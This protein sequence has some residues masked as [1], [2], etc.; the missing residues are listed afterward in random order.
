MGEVELMWE[1]MSEGH[2]R[3]ATAIAIVAVLLGMTQM[4]SFTSGDT[5]MYDPERDAFIEEVAAWTDPGGRGADLRFNFS[6]D[7]SMILLRGYGS[8]N[9]LRV[10]DLEMETLAVLPRVEMPHEV[11]GFTWSETDRWIVAWSRPEGGGPDFLQFFD[12]P[13]FEPNTS[14]PWVDAIDLPTIDVVTMLGHDEIAM[15]A[16]RDSNSTSILLVIEVEAARVHKRFVW[17]GNH[18]IVVAGD[19]GRETVI[20]D[21]GG[22]IVMMAGFDW[23]LRRQ[24][25]NA[26]VG[27]PRSW[28]I[29]V[30]QQWAFGD[31]AGRLVMSHNHPFYNQYNITV[32]EGPVTGF[33]WTDGRMWDFMAA[34]RHQDGGTRLVGWQMM[35]EG[36]LGGHQELC[37]KDLDGNVTMMRPDHHGWGRVLVAFEDGRL[38]SYRLNVR[39]FP[40]TMIPGTPDQVDWPGFEPFRKWRHEDAKGEHLR[41]RFNHRGSLIMLHGFASPDD[42]RVV[43]RTMDTVAVLEPPYDEFEFVDLAWSANDQWLLGW[44]IVPD[45][46]VTWSMRAILFD[47]PTFDVNT[48]SLIPEYILNVTY[49]IWSAV[50]LPGDDILAMSCGNITTGENV[51]LFLDLHDGSVVKEVPQGTE[52]IYDL[53]MDGDDLVAVGYNAIPMTFSP[54]DW[55]LVDSGFRLDESYK[56]FDAHNASGWAVADNE[57]NLTI[58]NGTPREL[59]FRGDTGIRPIF[60]ATWTRFREGDLVIAIHRVLA[61]GTNLQLW[62]TVDRPGLP[63]MRML[64]QVNSSKSFVQME[65]DPAFLGLMAVSFSDG[66]FALYHMN[67]TPYPPPP[68]EIS[69]LDIGPIDEPPNG[70]GGDGNGTDGGDDSWGSNWSNLFPVLLLVALVALVAGYVWLRSSLLRGDSG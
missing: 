24:Y 4:P 16:G 55:E 34:V 47:V 58:Y 67:V 6:T 11:R 8:P 30:D 49:N 59:A 23:D 14:V 57:Y 31:S 68:E 1:M 45:P 2:G 25:E 69:G 20:V 54:P 12:V 43:N 38:S 27:S 42:I 52:E 7:G 17:E 61:E 33:S 18:T 19:T 66:T 37:H 29:P 22:N 39:P 62:Q 40:V 32:G 70:N 48:T 51:I 36:Y 44:G 46:E 26:M 15:V 56:T 64:G 10:V 41:F 50:F 5:F 65:A 53:K 3:W 13:S 9:E 63:G 21:S 60:G 35:G 28:Y